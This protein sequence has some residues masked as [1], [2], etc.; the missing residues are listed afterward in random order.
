MA[1]E[2]RKQ[3]EQMRSEG[4][5]YNEIA[6]ALGI[7]KGMLSYWFNPKTREGYKERQRKRRASLVEQGLTTRGTERK[8]A[9]EL[10]EIRQHGGRVG[11][12]ASGEKRREVAERN[13]KSPKPKPRKRVRTNTSSPK[14]KPV[15]KPRGVPANIL[16]RPL[17]N[18]MSRIK[19]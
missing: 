14:K 2:R 3:A 19:N 6:R 9:D 13:P 4:A 15:A 7:N 11:G 17:P 1:R 10:L 18:T 16:R 5:T 12:L 8:S